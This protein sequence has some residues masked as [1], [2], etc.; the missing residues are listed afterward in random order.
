[1]VLAQDYRCTNCGYEAKG[2]S[3]DFDFGFSGM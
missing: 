1:M 2:V 3:E